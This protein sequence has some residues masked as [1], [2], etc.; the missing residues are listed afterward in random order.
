MIIISED[1]W[2][3]DGLPSSKEGGGEAKGGGSFNHCGTALKA[4]FGTTPQT[5]SKNLRV[6]SSSGTKI[7]WYKNTLVQIRAGKLTHQNHTHRTRESL[8][9]WRLTNRTRV[10]SIPRYMPPPG[11]SATS[12]ALLRMN[13]CQPPLNSSL[14]IYRIQSRLFVRRA[15][16]LWSGDRP[17][18][19]HACSH[20]CPWRRGCSV[21]WSHFCNP[22]S[23]GTGVHVGLCA[24]VFSYIWPPMWTCGSVNL[25]MC[26]HIRCKVN[27]VESCLHSDAPGAHTIRWGYFSCAR[28]IW[29]SFCSR[30][31]ATQ[32]AQDLHADVSCLHES[33]SKQIWQ[34]APRFAAPR[35]HSFRLLS[36]CRT[37]VCS[38]SCLWT[39]PCVS[40]RF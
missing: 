40:F 37:S 9:S 7:Q 16:W 13:Y 28:S 32:V 18:D 20:K 1:S 35:K 27:H 10:V 8:E 4:K 29:L 23:F 5:W 3:S 39:P 36:V 33:S 30:V 31:H 34:L 38:G 26:A 12:T 14:S 25:H 22:Q 19:T 21:T 24:N 15:W 6:G 17:L 11:P 2:I